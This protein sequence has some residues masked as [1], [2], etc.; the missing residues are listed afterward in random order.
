MRRLALMALFLL[1]G[2]S[3]DVATFSEQVDMRARWDAQNI[4][5]G[6]YKAD[7][8]A[9]MRNYL[10]NP[11][12]V[13]GAMISPPQIKTVGPG[14]RFVACVRFNARDSDGK[15]MG[16]K[17]GGA[18]FVLGKLDQFIDQ[19]KPAHEICKDAVYAPFPELE[20]LTR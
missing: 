12:Q 7:V 8:L 3:Q 15:Y 1:G 10:N 16:V 6:N 2:C 9:Y 18:V 5:P 11:T 14:Q 19:P 17:D 20:K 13:R 4:A